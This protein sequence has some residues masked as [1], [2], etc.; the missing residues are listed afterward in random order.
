[1]YVLMPLKSFGTLTKL[2]TALSER[3]VAYTGYGNESNK[4]LML[5]LIAAWY[6]K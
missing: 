4:H 6:L 1:M 5:L 2:L 3:N